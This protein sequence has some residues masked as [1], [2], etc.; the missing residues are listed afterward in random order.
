MDF[1]LE[2]F[3]SSGATIAYLLFAGIIFV[4]SGIIIG[5]LLPGDSLLVTAGLLAAQGILDVSV[6][7]SIGSVAA[8]LGGAVGYA[9]GRAVGPSL[10]SRPDSKYF[11]R[12]HLLKA[13]KFYKKYGIATIIAARFVPFVRTFAPILAGVAVMKY[14]TF[15]TFNIIGGIF[16]VC[17]L[18]LAGYWLGNV[19][20][21]L[22]KYLMFLVAGVIMLSLIPIAIEATRG[23]RHSRS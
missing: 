22:E 3:T 18:T 20:P 15:V 1:I 8:I 19:V 16:W 7:L 9:F 4:G 23:Q 11:R 14:H 21:N 17:S 6:L 10:F 13:H 2:L 5:F 12:N